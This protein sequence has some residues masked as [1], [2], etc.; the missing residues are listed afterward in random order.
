MIPPGKKREQ[1]ESG[2]ILVLTL[3]VTLVILGVGLTAMWISSSGMKMSGNLTRRQ[4]A[5]YASEAGME[6]ARSILANTIKWDDLLN[7]CAGHSMNDTGVGGRGVILCEG[8]IAGTPLA[9]YLIASG[10][11]TTSSKVRGLSN[12]TYTVY[13]RNDEAEAADLTIGLYNDEDSRIVVRAEGTGRDGL[14]FFAIEAIMSKASSLPD[15]DNYSQLGGSAQNQ[16][17]SKGKMPLN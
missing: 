6:H 15:E 7:G 3:L 14:S 11:S 17:S 8:G 4:E 10:A 16:N 13:I 5:L 9:N 1:D 12:I 2:S